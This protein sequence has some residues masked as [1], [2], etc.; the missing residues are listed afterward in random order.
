MTL[1]TAAERLDELEAN[2]SPGSWSML[3]VPCAVP[4]GPEDRVADGPVKR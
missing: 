3:K 4:D 1:T 2:G